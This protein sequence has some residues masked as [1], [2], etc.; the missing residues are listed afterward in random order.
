M[1]DSVEWHDR[2]LFTE[3]SEKVDQDCDENST[4]A[5]EL[6]RVVLLHYD[7]TEAPSTAPHTFFT[8][9]KFNVEAQKI[10]ELEPG[11][12]PMDDGA[13]APAAAPPPPK[14][15][16]NEQKWWQLSR[17]VWRLWR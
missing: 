1:P 10:S 3:D 15:R 5:I 16:R 13:A 17:R 11:A 9:R 2:E 4:A 6:F 14:P 7:Q 12:A 8:R